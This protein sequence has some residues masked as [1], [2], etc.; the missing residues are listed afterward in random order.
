M[1]VMIVGAGKL[2]YRLAEA[3]NNE[4]IDVTLMDINPNTLERI[5]DH[6]DVLTVE[7]NGIQIAILKEFNIETYDLIVATTDSDETN[8]LICTL[9]KKLHC[10]KAI[11]RIRNPEFIEQLDFV[12]SELGIDHIINPDLTTAIEIER[13]V[14]KTYNFYSGDFAKGKVSMVDFHI[15]NDC[16][17]IGK[18]IMDL[19]GLEG[20]LITAISREGELIIPNG[21][22]KIK[23]GDVIYVIG[24]SKNINR[25]GQ[26]LGINMNKKK[27][28]KV[29]ILGGGNI[30]YYLAQNLE[31]SG[32][33]VTILEKDK[34]RCEYLASK[35]N[36]AL[37]IHGDGTDIDLLQE[38]DLASYDTF[39]GA[40]GYD[41]QNLLMALVAKNSGINKAI[42]KISRHNYV[43]VVDKLDVDVALN[44]VNITVSN[45]LKYIRG[46]RVV[47]VSLLL[48]GEGEVTEIIASENSPIIGKPLYKLGLPKGIIIGAIVH[49][50]DVI[51]PD[52]NSVIHEDDRIII[53]SLVSDLPILNKLTQPAK[54]GGIFNE[55]WGSH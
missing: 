25:L 40:T 37:I 5:N 34:N 2:G 13:Y 42:A 29:M 36:C 26:N 35:L 1:K 10:K 14:S 54:K 31:R 24:K 27:T 30:G 22:T 45:V 53:F 43:H 20:L 4:N 17:F 52:G 28:K 15:G 11:A 33:S 32:I 51:I 38:E 41:E 12:K 44:P 9:S 23:F 39:I 6:L 18:R 16:S 55:L 49:K 21:S 8:T 48:G 46:G 50:E 47:S 7:A 3:M 19:K